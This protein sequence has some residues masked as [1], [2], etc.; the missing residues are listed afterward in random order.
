MEYAFIPRILQYCNCT[1]HNTHVHL[2]SFFHFLLQPLLVC[3]PA[4]FQLVIV[5]N[6]QKALKFKLVSIYLG[7][8]LFGCA[9]FMT[10]L[11]LPLAHQLAAAIKSAQ[12]PYPLQILPILQT[13]CHWYFL[14][15]SP[16]LCLLE[17]AM[18]GFLHSTKVA[19]CVLTPI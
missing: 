16:A 11:H 9:S 10:V 14:C 15:G 17:F 3:G 1:V 2:D 18:C 7:V 13:F 6:G 5:R 4:I 12:T 19:L 8:S